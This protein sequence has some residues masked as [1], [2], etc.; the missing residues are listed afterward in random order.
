MPSFSHRK[1]LSSKAVKRSRRIASVRIHVE[2][3]IGRMKTFRIWSGII[4]IKLRFQL[5]Q[6][7]TI[8]AT[9]CNLKDRVVRT[10]FT[11]IL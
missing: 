8:I 7:I 1:G 11:F 2:Q 5:N 9:L 3:A 6:V 10:K 4:P